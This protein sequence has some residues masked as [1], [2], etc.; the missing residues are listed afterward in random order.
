MKV[1]E[2]RSILNASKA[3]WA[4]PADIADDTELEAIS[5]PFAMG[6]MPPAPGAPTARS[7]RMRR[8]ADAAVALWQPGGNRLTRPFVTALPRTWD[9]RD[10]HGHTWI[11]PPKNQG[12]C[13][14]CVAFGVS[15]AL[16]AHQRIEAND[17][18]L[19]FD[20]SEANLFFVNER[21][22]NLGDPRYGW[23]I[24]PALDYL[25]D[26]GACPE[27]DYPYRDVN[28][29]A[30]LVLG[31]QGTWKIKGYDSTS[32]V[33]QAKRWLCE[34]G[35][36]VTRFTVYQDFMTYW[37]L[38]ANGVYTHH[39]GS[40][41]GGHAVAVIGYSDEQSCWICKNSWGSTH[42]NDG[43]FRI[44]YGQCGIDDRMYLI[45]DVYDVLTRDEIAYNPRTLR[46]VDEGARGW[47]LTDGVSRMKILDSKE[48][49]R[50]ALCV[51]RRYTRQ[52]FVGR[53]NR[54]ANRIDYITEYWA[55]NSGLPHEPLT[56]EDAIPYDPSKV[57]AEDIDADGWRLRE[58]SHWM[59]LAD[60]LNDA[61][62]VLQIVERYTKMCFIG[63]GN[64]RPDRKS[65]IMTYWE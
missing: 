18:S 31:T 33:R 22:C 59:L 3:Q 47:L 40:T 15:A 63:R 35:P 60:D 65:Y 58:G 7:P 37:S 4:I 43:C 8:P 9:W 27:E 41:L 64:H 30:E 57:V 36:L 24:P 12:G 25:V 53:D 55:G 42:G 50:N 19:P 49:A 56:R 54:R 6:G 46:I 32:N 5:R 28:Q 39:A 48:D 52:G 29:N 21:Q 62:A 26:Q 44:G 16:E 38:G 10:V 23:S 34:D 14:S 17:A 45:Q 11:S 20:T 51:A 2:L 1:K 13:G 61:L